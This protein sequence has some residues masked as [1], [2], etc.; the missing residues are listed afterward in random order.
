MSEKEGLPTRLGQTHTLW[1]RE[2][3]TKKETE[4]ILNPL[5][6]ERPG[7]HRH[8]P[9]PAAGTG[10]SWIKTSSPRK[11]GL[12]ENLS[13]ACVAGWKSEWGKKTEA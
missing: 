11:N 3:E 12:M 13:Q 2:W 1:A 5:M 4:N 6:S 7:G 8:V 10:G 9:P